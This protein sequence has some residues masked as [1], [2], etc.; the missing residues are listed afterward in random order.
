MEKDNEKKYGFLRKQTKWEDLYFYQKSVTLYQ[1][2]F[3]FAHRY[4]TNSD[5]TRD[6][7]IQGLE[8][9]ILWKALPMGSPQW[10]WK[11]NC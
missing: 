3:I 8:N 11:S 4:Y 10:K 1:L 9:K 5:R 7:L 2:S 6:Q